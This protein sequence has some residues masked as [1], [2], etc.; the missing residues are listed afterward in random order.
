MADRQLSRA[1]RAYVGIVGKLDPTDPEDRVRVA[2]GSKTAELVPLIKSVMAEVE[3]ERQT[4][5]QTADIS[6]M[7]RQIETMVRSRHPEISKKA[8]HAIAN[9]FTF[10]WR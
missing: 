2:F 4:F 7:G 3:A 8:A 1:I 10:D 6:E 5:W 9:K